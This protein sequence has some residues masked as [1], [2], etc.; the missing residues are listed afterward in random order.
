[1][2]AVYIGMDI[3]GTHIRV[4][5]NQ[6]K[7]VLKTA[8]FN[9]FMELM[10]LLVQSSSPTEIVCALAGPIDHDGGVSPPNIKKWG[11]VD[12]KKV[13][14]R[15]PNVRIRFINDLVAHAHGLDHVQPKDLYLLKKG[16][17]PDGKKVLLI[18]PG[19]GLGV[20]FKDK[21]HVYPSEAGHVDCPAY[22]QE[23]KK[24][25]DMLL[26]KYGHVSYERIVSGTGLEEIN[27]ILGTKGVQPLFTQ[28]LARFIA[29][30]TVTFLPE[31]IYLGGGILMH[32]LKE[33]DTTL[34][35]E[36][37]LDQG[38]FKEL[39]NRPNIYV[40]LDEFTALKGA[41]SLVHP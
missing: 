34:F 36:S 14:K 3:G 38:R 21:S 19:T 10:D 26:K 29:N 8:D 9:D 20:A 15:F 4:L 2:Q 27:Q 18:A 22:G 23:G 24:I 11:R 37:L 6:D 30:M 12:P 33:I 17:M 31:T 1:M 28:N 25:H 16:T 41:Y 32:R 39:V 35:V 40:I 13:E 7:T 5:K